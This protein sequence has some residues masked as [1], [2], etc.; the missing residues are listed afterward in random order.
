MSHPAYI[1]PAFSHMECEVYL[2]CRRPKLPPP[3]V[4][5]R[6]A[7]ARV[8]GKRLRETPHRNRKRAVEARGTGFG[9]KIYYFTFDT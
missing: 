3:F 9:R 5:A 4:P 6:G 7:R 8:A 2:D 1:H